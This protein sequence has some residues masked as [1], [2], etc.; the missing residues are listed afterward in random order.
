VDVRDTDRRRAL[1]AQ[2]RA[3]RTIATGGS[4]LTAGHFP[5]QR[6]FYASCARLKAALC[7][8]RA[9]KTFGGNSAFL[10]KASKTRHGRLLYV[11][12]TRAECKRLAWYGNRG[13]GMAMLVEKFGLDAVCNLSDLTIHFPTL[14]SWIYM[15]GA[16]DE[17]GIE[18]ALGGGYHEIWW[19]EAQKIPAKLTPRITETLMPTLLDNKGTLTLTGTPDRRM[20]G[21]FHEVTRPELAK[22]RR[23]WEVSHW[24]ILDNPWFGRTEQ[25][26]LLWWVVA[27][28]GDRVAG[29]FTSQL[30]AEAAIADVRMKEGPLE[31]QQ[32]LSVGQDLIPLDSPIMQRAGFGRWVQEDANYVYHVHQIARRKL[33]YAPARRHANGTPDFRAALADLPG[34][35]EAWRDYFFALGADL[36]YKPDPFAIVLWAWGK[37]GGDK[38]YEVCSWKA[39]ELTS[40]EQAAVLQSVTEI[41]KLTIMVADAGGPAKSTVQG[42]AKGYLERYPIPVTEAQKDNKDTWIQLMNADIVAGRIQ[43]RDDGALLAEMEELQWSVLIT[44]SGRMIEDPSMANHCCDAALYPFRHSYHFRWRPAVPPPPPGSPE[45]LL[46]EETQLEDAADDGTDE[47]YA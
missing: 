14:D 30:E 28:A 38:L 23:G 17:K 44:G 31:L 36:G 45:S 7:S 26:G 41:V 22:R 33:C 39:L 47:A 35:K 46:R 25:I 8:R 20:S 42:W 24:S 32:L 4:D 21:L 43:L 12:E 19:D 27:R 6:S 3:R 16:D 29:P 37:A 40:D 2:R 34:G 13:D 5:A 15:I 10:D 9:G 1:L 18:K 11:N